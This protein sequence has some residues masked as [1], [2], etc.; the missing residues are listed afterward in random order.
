[1]DVPLS[2]SYRSTFF[3][4]ENFQRADS[5]EVLGVVRDQRHAMTNRTGGDPGVMKINRPPVPL[6]FGGD[7]RIG[8]ARF[9]DRMARQRNF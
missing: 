2:P 6:P 8:R 1:M 5:L 9:H 7:P 3:L 4:R